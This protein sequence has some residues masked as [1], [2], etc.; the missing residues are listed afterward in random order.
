[1]DEFSFSQYVADTS[2]LA[3]L[4]TVAASLIDLKQSR[5][6]ECRTSRSGL[7][8]AVVGILLAVVLQLLRHR[9]A[10]EGC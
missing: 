2:G 9:A 4:G 1:M 10:S 8:G 5:G 6:L 3:A 7:V